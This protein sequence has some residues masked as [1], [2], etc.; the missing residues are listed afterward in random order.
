MHNNNNRDFITET[1]HDYSLFANLAPW[2]CNDDTT[3]CSGLHEV[4][5]L[6]N[7]AAKESFAITANPSRYARAPNIVL[8][9]A[10]IITK[11]KRN[12]A[13]SILGIL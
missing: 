6:I 11:G 12:I 8:N 10:P 4:E 9:T 13:R 5:A 2:L 3:D 7:P 1:H